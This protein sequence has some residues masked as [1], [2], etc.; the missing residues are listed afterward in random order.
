M[1]KDALVSII[2]PVYNGEKYISQSIE[3][4]LNQTYKN[5]ELIIVNDC[6]TDST[7]EIITLFKNKDS[8]V[9]IVN[10]KTNKKLPVSLNIGHDLAKG[11]YLTWTSDDNFYCKNAILKML[12]VLYDKNVDV[13]YADY[14]ILKENN[15]YRVHLKNYSC[16]I[17]SNTI[18]ACFLY[19]SEV[20]NELNKYDEQ[21]FLVE[22]Y[23]FWLGCLKKYKFYHLD[24]ALYNY[25]V[26]ELSLTKS[27]SDDSSRK[28]LFLNNIEKSYRKHF[29]NYNLDVNYFVHIFAKLHVF[30][31]TLNTKKEILNL[32]K[33]LIIY[34]KEVGFSENA[35][36]DLFK[37]IAILQLKL[38]RAINNK[39]NLFDC[40]KF[41]RMNYSFLCLK[42][43]K[44]WIK[45][46]L[47]L[48]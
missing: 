14:N 48:K 45:L 41:L 9:R 35:E 17:L 30:P 1:E 33:M 15:K 4:C 26:H 31:F 42:E 2:L 20:F 28:R 23:D 32:K 27:V 12:N 37:E 13:V 39:L 21:L 10:N 18:G 25:R 29:L 24:K 8:R 6:S 34:S 19:K 38:L 40:I 36:K 22:D 16:L 47:K 11:D 3:S 46:C 44:I 43:F 5:I 7:S